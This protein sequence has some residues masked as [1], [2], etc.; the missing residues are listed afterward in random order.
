VGIGNRE[1][2]EATPKSK[3][4]NIKDASPWGEQWQP[5]NENKTGVSVHLVS[6]GRSGPAPLKCNQMHTDPYNLPLPPPTPRPITQGLFASFIATM[7]RSDFS[8]PFVIGFDSSS[9]NADRSTTT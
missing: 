8:C 6:H 7:K 5:P 3:D 4:V 1:V 2:S 9:P